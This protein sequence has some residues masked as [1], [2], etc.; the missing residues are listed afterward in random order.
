[1][2]GA[3]RLAW[4]SADADPAMSLHGVFTE[5]VEHEKITHTEFMLLGSSQPIGSQV[6]THEFMET[7]G[8]TMM[9]ITQVYVSK[10]ARDGAFASGMDEGMESCYKQLDLAGTTHLA[11]A[12]QLH[13]RV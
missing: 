9:R 2:A 4:K 7:G 8:T 13:G 1:V 5:V 6:E 12:T 3:L 10:E 11:Q